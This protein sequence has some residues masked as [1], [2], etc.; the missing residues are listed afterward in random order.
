MSAPIRHSNLEIVAPVE[1]SGRRTPQTLLL[2]DERDKLLF[3]AARF[4]PGASDRE[5]ATAAPHR[6]VEV[7]RGRWGRGDRTEPLCPL[8]HRGTITEL[9]WMILQVN[10]HLPSDRTIRR[11]LPGSR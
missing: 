4:Y 1:R 2:L 9:L 3:E 10:D 5:V 7:S 6:T 11:A 8:R